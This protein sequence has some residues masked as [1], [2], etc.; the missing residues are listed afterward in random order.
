MKEITA[1]ILVIIFVQ[2]V[3]YGLVNAVIAKKSA[4]QKVKQEK[5]VI[6]HLWFL[7]LFRVYLL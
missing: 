1:I 5:T 2:T 7:L 3:V 4:K 6:I